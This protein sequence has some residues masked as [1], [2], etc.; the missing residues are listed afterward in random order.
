MCE[1]RPDDKSGR[2]VLLV[3][4]PGVGKTTLI[5]RIVQGLSRDGIPA[6]GFLTA[7]VRDAQGVRQGF[8]YRTLSGTEGWLAR[9]GAEAA[10]RVGSYGVNLEGLERD[11]VSEIDPNAVDAGLIII[12]EI[13]KMESFSRIFRGAVERA[14]DSGHP[15][16]ASV[17]SSAGGWIGRV[18]DRED[19]R[20]LEVTEQNRDE[21]ARELTQ[22]I[23]DAL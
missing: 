13:G 23:I 5:E 11:A 22:E 3:G 2:N 19:A 15:V 14:L 6:S 21:L 4:R 10:Y 12:D 8:R 1:K 16:L 17:S 18:R 9:R 20:L 7:E